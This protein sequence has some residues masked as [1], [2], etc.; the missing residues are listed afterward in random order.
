LDADDLADVATTGEVMGPEEWN[1]FRS[2][3]LPSL[4]EICT[5]YDEPTIGE[6]VAEEGM[7]L[8]SVV[9]DVRRLLELPERELSPPLSATERR[10][11]EI[12]IE[13]CG[14]FDR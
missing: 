13:I 1:A 6:L 8:S 10:E 12:V 2:E 3:S 5:S 11:A 9:N 14:R 4:I 7:T